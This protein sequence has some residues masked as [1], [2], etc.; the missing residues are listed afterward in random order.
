[1][2]HIESARGCAIW[3]PAPQSENLFSETRFFRQEKRCFTLKF[4]AMG[5]ISFVNIG[6]CQKIRAW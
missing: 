4:E 1:M 3:E 6:K 5:P 2:A